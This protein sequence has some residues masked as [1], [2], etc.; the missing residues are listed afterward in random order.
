MGQGSGMCE[1]QQGR[2]G[3]LRS[4]LFDDECEIRLVF[5]LRARNKNCDVPARTSPDQGCRL[6]ARRL[7]FATAG[8]LVL[9]RI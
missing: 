9:F 2:R 5:I 7:A 8:S 1:N 6:R 4:S 3:L